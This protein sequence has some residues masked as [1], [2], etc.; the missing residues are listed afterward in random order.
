MNNKQDDSGIG[1][2]ENS[3]EYGVKTF[4]DSMNVEDE[5]I[6]FIGQPL[7]PD[8]FLKFSFPFYYKIL[9]N[10]LAILPRQS[11]DNDLA[12]QESLALVQE[13]LNGQINTKWTLSVPYIEKNVNCIAG[14]FYKIEM[15][16][17]RPKTRLLLARNNLK[18]GLSLGSL[19]EIAEQIGIEKEKTNQIIE[20]LEYG[21]QIELQIRIE[22]TRKRYEEVNL[23][24]EKLFK[25]YN[26]LFT[27]TVPFVGAGC[28]PDIA[29]KGQ[30]DRV[31]SELNRKSKNRANETV[32]IY[33]SA[34]YLWI[35]FASEEILDLPLENHGLRENSSLDLR[36]LEVKSLMS[37]LNKKVDFNQAEI[38]ETMAAL[39]PTSIKSLQSKLNSLYQ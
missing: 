9:R 4:L 5:S 31:S 37:A 24:E 33:P 25:Y 22:S 7:R 19:T 20:A 10:S 17:I 29:E 36:I 21:S 15:F 28:E 27:N 1:E 26:L 34:T 16:V 14:L 2:Q 3:F 35:L 11:F 23:C 13:L 18:R 30:S 39:V 6:E 12:A 8:P 32:I 38:I